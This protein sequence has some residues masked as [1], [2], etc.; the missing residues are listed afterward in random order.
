MQGLNPNIVET[1]WYPDLINY[2]QTTKN[3]ELYPN[4]KESLNLFSSMGDVELA[5][6]YLTLDF[7]EDDVEFHSLEGISHLQHLR[8]LN[9]NTHAV[10]R[11]E[12]SMESVCLPYLE[13]MTVYCGNVNTFI[14]SIR[15]CPNLKVFETVVVNDANFCSQCEEALINTAGPR[16]PFSRLESLYIEMR[17]INLIN[18]TVLAESLHRCF[19]QL[20]T[21][22]TQ[23][24]INS[25]E[26]SGEFKFDSMQLVQILSIMESRLKE[27][28]NIDFKSVW[29]SIYGRWPRDFD[30]YFHPV[31][32]K[33]FENRRLKVEFS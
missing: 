3:L 22:I 4:G 18:L 11:Y 16:F 7:W 21:L 20:T 2:I 14:T 31:V 29:F 19:P 26:F 24:N 6:T 1:V 15:K 27:L 23:L 13:A 9:I 5:V 8:E 32:M 30:G 28:V 33:H 10:A 25:D 12:E 17:H